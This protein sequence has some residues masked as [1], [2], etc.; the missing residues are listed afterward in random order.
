[1]ELKNTPL[2]QRPALINWHY[3][4]TTEREA[5]TGFTEADVDKC[6]LDEDNDSIWRL[7]D[8]DPITW[9]EVTSIADEALNDYILISDQKS[10]NTDGG[11]FTSGAW[12]TRTLNT[13]VSDS[14]NH[15]SVASNQITLAAGT[16]R[17]RASAPGKQCNG[18]MVKLY[19]ITNSVD[20]LLGT[21]MFAGSGSTGE[22]RSEVVGE[23]TI[24]APKVIELQH[25]CETTRNTDGFGGPA[26]I[27]ETET[28]AIVELVK[29]A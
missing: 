12:R 15:A 19:N 22:N 9:V 11:S 21:S 2:G 25:R 5:A 17:V 18:H 3:A 6:A 20:I 8:H 16:Y 29:V 24:A 23:F 1:M 10:A 7:K 4:D 14:G 26:N 27:G 28:Y 13:E